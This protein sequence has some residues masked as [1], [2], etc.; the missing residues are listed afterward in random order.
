MRPPLLACLLAVAA[1]ATPPARQAAQRCGDD[2]A[3]PVLCDGEG[4]LIACAG[5][6]PVVAQDG[7][8]A[9]LRWD[10]VGFLATCKDAP[11]DG[12]SP[13][14]LVPCGA[15][16]GITGPVELVTLA[17]T[18]C[19]LGALPVDEEEPPVADG[20]P[21]AGCPCAAGLVCDVELDVC[22]EPVECDPFAASPCPAG[23]ECVLDQDAALCLPVPAE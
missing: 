9:C 19:A 17:S 16:D 12:P 14:D 1:C 23:T 8:G 11:G 4:R 21:Y 7:I 13:A 15:C 5:D 6:E 10:G 20:A 3:A 22:I 18:T 2:G